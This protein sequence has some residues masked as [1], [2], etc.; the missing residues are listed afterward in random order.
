MSV[1]TLGETMALFDPAEDG[2]PA[3]GMS[4]TLRFAGAESNFAIALARLG[5]PVRWVSRLGA[6]PIGD[7][8]VR[9]LEAEGVDIRWVTRDPS[10][11]TG[12]FMKIRKHGTTGVQYFRRG[13]AASRLVPADVPDE[14]FAGVQVVHLTGITLALSESA[15]SVIYH[16]AERARELG[17]LVTFDANYRPALWQDADDARRAQE[18]VLPL[19]DW[20]FCGV[21]EARAL[22]GDGDPAALERRIRSAGARGVVIRVGDRGAVI[23][24]AIVAPQRIVDVKDEVGAGDAFDAGFV[25]ALLRG[26]EPEQCVRAGHIIAA[27][28]L[29]GTGDWETLPHLRD[30][31]SHLTEACL[32]ASATTLS[33]RKQVG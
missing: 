16:V 4:Y 13:S 5:V 7:L 23:N 18:R 28:A 10:A 2:A 25:W 15:R 32:G 3:I 19:V 1:L 30:V 12:A 31:Q 26:S 14:A 9:T 17:V 24:G 27:H 29:Q 33:L 20:Y 11:T 21:E 22:W 8:I 6:D